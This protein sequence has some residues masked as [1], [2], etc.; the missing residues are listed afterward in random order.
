MLSEKVFEETN[1][2]IN[3]FE[4]G[5]FAFVRP[6][7]E[8]NETNED[9][10]C[11]TELWKA[12]KLTKNG[13]RSTI[14]FSLITQF[15]PKINV[16]KKF[17]ALKLFELNL[18]LL[19]KATSQ[20]AGVGFYELKLSNP[21][22]INI[23][24]DKTLIDKYVSNDKNYRKIVV[25]SSINDIDKNSEDVQLYRENNEYK[26]H[27]S[28]FISSN[29][30]I[31]KFDGK[32]FKH[33]EKT[34]PS[35]KKTFYDVLKNINDSEVILKETATLKGFYDLFCSQLT[36]WQ[37]WLKHNG[38]PKAY[39]SYS[40]GIANIEKKYKVNIDEEYKK[41]KCKSLLDMI[42]V[43]PD[44]I[45]SKKTKNG[46]KKD[47]SSHIYKYIA[48]KDEQMTNNANN[49]IENVDSATETDEINNKISND[50][51][52]KKYLHS[53]TIFYG[54]PGCGKS[55]EINKLL[56]IDKKSRDN[57]T[58]LN[59]KFYKRILFHPE[60][61]YSDFI[62]QIVP[63]TDGEKITYEFQPGPFVE[64][65]KDAMNDGYNNYFL[66]IEEINRG[67]APAIFGDIFQLLD[68]ADDRC[69]EYP[70]YNR[71]IANYLF[72]ENSNAQKIY[73]PKNLTIFATMNTSDQNVFTLD[74]A[75]KR[76]WRFTRIPNDFDNKS[77]TFLDSII[78]D[79]KYKWRDFAS[80]LN[81]DIIEHC[82]D[83]MIAEDK[84]LGTHF[85]KPHE[86]ED[87]NVFAEKVF[88]YLWND[89]VKYN[90]E[91]LFRSDLKTLD[92]VINEFINNKNVFHEK[93]LNMKELYDNKS[94]E[95]SDEKTQ[96]E[97]NLSENLTKDGVTHE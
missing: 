60:Y 16:N 7:K 84:L 73:I 28:A 64:I 59:S 5:D 83:G 88:M 94:A 46:P 31:N 65:L 87:L 30:I 48:Y 56:K 82:N 76:R 91:M 29:D 39:E 22:A 86:L 68:R 72:N 77:D 52:F 23:I 15:N 38:V 50:E 57:G 13:N 47:W 25:H 21:S 63:K 40:N 45:K 9:R 67:N 6:T 35:P 96:K 85:V 95:A 41:D 61:S 34:G 1:K 43:D 19:N 36:D 10:G 80:K 81:K 62:G 4:E 75:F 69:S 33:G 79:T 55:Y 11:V 97:E 90:K 54:V 70:I 32:K 24:R 8:K 71:N 20:Q 58:V 89:V 51:N 18:N 2:Y 53:N 44:V 74:T 42:S 37:Y 66:I 14:E 49:F 93:C 12:T 92:D 3:G 17:I 78:G 26:L 27:P